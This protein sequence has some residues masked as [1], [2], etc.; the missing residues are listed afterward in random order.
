MLFPN[1][2]RPRRLLVIVNPKG[3]KGKAR[4]LYLREVLPLLEAAGITVTMLGKT[5]Y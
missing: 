1:A 3:G 2:G 5:R 4:E